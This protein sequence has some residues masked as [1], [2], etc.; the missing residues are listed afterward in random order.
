MKHKFLG[1]K[2]GLFLNGEIPN[3]IR[4]NYEKIFIT[5]G[6]FNYIKNINILPDFIIGDL[7]SIDKKNNFLIKNSIIINKPNQNITDFEKALKFIINNKFLNI[8]IWGASGKENDHFLGNLSV[9]LKFNKKLSLIF[10]D[11]YHIYFFAKKKNILYGMKNKIIS[12]FPFPYVQGIITKG[13]KYSLNNQSLK[14][15]KN[16]GIRNFAINDIIEIN[17]QK[18]VLIIFIQR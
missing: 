8:D 13:L 7:D 10:Y 6:A 3:N 17:Y 11:K 4:T 16:I 12:L 9:A 18:G 2:V 15:G 14:I 5:D 1:P